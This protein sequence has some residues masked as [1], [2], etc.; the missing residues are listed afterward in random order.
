MA[1]TVRR[2]DMPRPT[3]KDKDEW[4]LAEPLPYI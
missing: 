2:E 3:S 4:Y 1:A